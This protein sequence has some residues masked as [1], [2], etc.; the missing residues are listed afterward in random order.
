MEDKKK[1]NDE[2][3]DKVVGGEVEISTRMKCT[4]CRYVEYWTGDYM[5]K[6][7]ECPNCHKE[8]LRGVGNLVEEF[9]D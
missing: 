2:E 1:L 6:D 9:G 8:T 7:Y 4:S 3:L 5:G